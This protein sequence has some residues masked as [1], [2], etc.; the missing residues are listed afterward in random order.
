LQP[1]DSETRLA[2]L[3]FRANQRG[4]AIGL[5]V[6][7]FIA[8][9]AQRNVRELEGALNRVVAYAKLNR[10]IPTI[11]MARKALDN[12]S[13]KEYNPDLI[14]PAF[15]VESVANSFRLS[16][17]DLKGRKREKETALA[18]RLAMYLIRQE[19]N[20]SLSQIGQEIGNRDA[21]AVTIACK[22]ISTDISSSPYLKRKIREIQ[23][24]IHPKAKFH[25]TR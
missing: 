3:Q 24:N 8:Q 1:P 12:L 2:I 25:N 23:R 9:Q 19:T 21:A 5:D 16:V 10:A 14:T 13:S 7:E 17:E 22:K 4:A 20:S 15:I 11:E 6:L 18:R